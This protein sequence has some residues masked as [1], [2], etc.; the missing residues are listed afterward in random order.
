MKHRDILVVSTFNDNGMHKYGQR[1]INSFAKNVDKQIR[2]V[3]YAE[4]CVPHNPDPKQIEILDAVEHLPKLVEFKNKWRD[5]P[6]ANGKCPPEIARTRK[7]DAHKEFKW[8]AVRFANKTYAVFEAQHKTQDWLVWLDADTYV[9]SPVTYNDMRALLPD[10][11]WI[12]YVGRGIGSASWPECGF[13]GMN[14]R[15]KTCVEFLKE[16]ELMYEDADNGIFRLTEWHDSFVF[17]H[18]LKKYKQQAPTVHDYT[19]QIKLKTARSGGGGHPLINTDLGKYFDHLKGDRKDKKKSNKPGD[20][21]V[22]RN[23]GYWNG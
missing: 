19:G 8:D 9:H 21:I 3:I 10:K 2:L 13:Y 7:G 20:L 14:L 11:T 15:K 5:V 6:K 16:F 1:L 17:G 18:L 23:E 4:N 12:T 22:N